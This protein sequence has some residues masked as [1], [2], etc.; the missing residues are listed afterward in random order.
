M[1]PKIQA[2]LGIGVTVALAVIAELL[3]DGGAMLLIVIAGL[4]LVSAVGGLRLPL[5]VRVFATSTTF[6][7]GYQMCLLGRTTEPHLTA[8]NV[9]IVT[10]R[11]KMYHLRSLQ[12]VPPWRAL[13]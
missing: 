5:F 11:I 9:Q 6:N 12:S 3:P 2:A 10:G 1:S 4:T 7:F 13:V 8:D